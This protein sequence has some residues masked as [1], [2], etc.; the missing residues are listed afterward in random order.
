MSYHS[1]LHNTDNNIKECTQAQK[2][3]KSLLLIALVWR[4][5]WASTHARCV[6]WTTAFSIHWITFWLP[7]S[8][9][10]F[11]N[12]TRKMTFLMYISLHFDY[13]LVGSRRNHYFC[14]ISASKQGRLSQIKQG[15]LYALS[16]RGYW[17]LVK[18]YANITKTTTPTFYDITNILNI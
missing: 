8:N 6:S 12:S 14:L 11:T 13:K 2:Y 1:K 10:M 16:C 17:N 3:R 4:K 9:W 15:L 7:I 18:Q 5:N